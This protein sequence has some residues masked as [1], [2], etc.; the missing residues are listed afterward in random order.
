MDLAGVMTHAEF[1]I[2]STEQKKERRRLQRIK[3]RENNREKIN[4]INRKYRENNREKIN[5]GKRRYYK[6]HKEEENERCRKYREE[7]KEQI[8]ETYKKYRQTANGKKME[9]LLKWK[10]RGLQE[11]KEDLEWIYDLYLNQE[12]CYSCDVKLTRNGI[13]STEACMD[14]DHTTNRFRQICCRSCNSQDSWMKYW[15]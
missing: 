4:E 3:Y 13:C 5:E 7:H 8:A 6:E 1:N 9:T 15:C 2:L 11:S 10:Y 12:L 14:H